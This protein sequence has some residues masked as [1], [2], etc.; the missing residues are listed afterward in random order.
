MVNSCSSFVRVCFN[1]H[2]IFLF[3]H[4]LNHNY[5]LQNQ[6]GEKRRRRYWETWKK[7]QLVPH[8]KMSYI[9]EQKKLNDLCQCFILLCFVYSLE[10]S[11]S[12]QCGKLLC[13][14][15]GWRGGRKM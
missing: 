2:C 3:S 6:Q 12:L 13:H 11:L 8:V 15:G 9:R 14:N 1:S 4:V 7:H 10:Y 5:G